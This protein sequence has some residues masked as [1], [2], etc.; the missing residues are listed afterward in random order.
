MPTE[1]VLERNKRSTFWLTIAK[2]RVRCDGGDKP[3]APLSTFS[4][5]CRTNDTLA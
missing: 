2:P 4:F 3:R 1:V 5:K